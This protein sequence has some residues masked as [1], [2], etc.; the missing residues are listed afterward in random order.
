[1]VQLARPELTGAPRYLA[2]VLCFWWFFLLRKWQGA[3]NS[4]SWSSIGGELW[5]RTRGGK[6]QASTFGDGGRKLE[7]T[8]HDKVGQ[9]GCDAGCRTPT[10]G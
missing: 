2:M 9:N 5:S 7:G 1:M 3:R 8:A 10:S 6:A 4:P